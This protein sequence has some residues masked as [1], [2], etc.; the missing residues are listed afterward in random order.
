[1][2]EK[3]KSQYKQIIKPGAI[4]QSVAMSV[5]NQEA[6]RLI[7]ASGTSF[8]EDL[9]IKIFLL[10]LIQEEH[11]SVNDEKMCATYW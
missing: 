2:T 3:V 4:A 8:R 9:V 5:G 1:M 11:L 7:L 6:P 10:P